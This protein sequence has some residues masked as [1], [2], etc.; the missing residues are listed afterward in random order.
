MTD[1]EYSKLQ[2]KDVDEVV[3]LLKEFFLK[4]NLKEVGS[5]DPFR[6]MGILFN[7]VNQESF[8]GIVVRDRGELVGIIT[9]NIVPNLFQKGNVCAEQIWYVKDSHRNTTIG[10][11]LFDAMERWAKSKGCT[12]IQVGSAEGYSNVSRIYSKLGYT[13]IDSSY[14]K[15]I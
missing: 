6:V 10:M 14:W 1:L 13:K 5:F 15:E 12:Q 8:L 4:S 2:T 9:A 3:P 7:L 11:R